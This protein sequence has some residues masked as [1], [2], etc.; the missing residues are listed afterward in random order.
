MLSSHTQMV[1]WSQYVSVVGVVL[2]VSTTLAGAMDRLRRAWLKQ[3]SGFRAP[4]VLALALPRFD[5]ADVSFRVCA[6][7]VACSELRL[8]LQDTLTARP[9]YG[10]RLG[11]V[12]VWITGASGGFGEALALALAKAAKPKG[13]ILSARREEALLRVKSACCQLAAELAV[14]VLP[15][16]LAELKTL[17]QKASEAKKLFGEVD[18]LIN[19]G[20]VGFRGLGEET[21]IEVDQLVMNVDYFS[22]VILTKSL[23]PD[24]LQRHRGHVV[25]VS[26]VQGFFGLPGRTAYAAAKHAA[27]G[28]Y[29]ALRAEVS[30]RGVEVTTICPGYI[31]TGHSQNAVKGEG[32]SPA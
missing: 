18:V 3:L 17:P 24:W 21:S 15:L 16:D 32:V 14:K 29:D 25:Q 23:L 22:G 10:V 1:E 7:W 9:K 13:I 30:E 20:G 19:N 26:S 8:T 12:V 27:V 28:F 4:A 5:G 31:A 11:S 6:P 2:Q